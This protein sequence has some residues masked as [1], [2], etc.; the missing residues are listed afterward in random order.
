MGFL[1]NS[2]DIV[3]DAVLTDTG[4]MR[5][6]KGDGSFKVVKFAFSDS[7]IDYSNYRNS[8]HP[9]GAHASGS[10][11]Y[12]LEIMQTPILEAF[13]NNASSMRSKLMS[14]P[15]SNLLYM[16]VMK[17]W[18]GYVNGA[19]SKGPRAWHPYVSSMPSGMSG[20]YLV[21]V[22]PSTE[23]AFSHPDIQGV[24]WGANPRT[25]PATIVIDQG[26]DNEDRITPL[27][28]GLKET[29][30]LIE[31]DNRLG[32]PVDS[33]GQ[34][35][36]H[37]FTDDDQIATYAIDQAMTS[38][39]EDISSNTQDWDNNTGNGGP[40]LKG[41]ARGSRLKFR[42]ASQTEVLQG[43]RL[44]ELIGTQWTGATFPT[45]IGAE[46]ASRITQNNL[47]ARSTAGELYYIDSPVRIIGATTGYRLDIVI[48]YVKCTTCSMG[49]DR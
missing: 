42:I 44:F 7:E 30:Y 17:V 19:Y 20:S 1:D 10:A 5:L 34:A 36:R 48:R 15:V 22:D 14:F 6:A 24:M 35:A 2:G 16:P 27:E 8:N 26:I 13:T 11:Y 41:K 31:I 28:I 43:K 4:R 33:R 12:D 39:Y 29:Q 38:F 21:A 46:V 37:L 32:R 18:D 49:I 47:T 23:V 9:N 40:M 45:V 25:S 3:L